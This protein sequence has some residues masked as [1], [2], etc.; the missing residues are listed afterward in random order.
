MQR[1]FHRLGDAD[2]AVLQPHVALAH[3]IDLVA[4]VHDIAVR[5]LRRD[6]E[7]FQRRAD[8]GV[9]VER[10]HAAAARNCAVGGVEQRLRR[11]GVHA[12]GQVGR[13]VGVFCRYI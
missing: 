13:L 9:V 8:D 3:D 11:A 4:A 7:R 10:G 2:L 12:H 6:T 1:E 5:V